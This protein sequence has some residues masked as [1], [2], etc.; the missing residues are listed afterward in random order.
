MVEFNLTLFIELGLFLFFLWL[1]KRMVFRPMLSVMDQREE[2]IARDL[3]EAR[4][5]ETEAQEIEEQYAR[6][7]AQ[8]RQ[9]AALERERRLQEARTERTRE[10]AQRRRKMLEEVE[11][12][13]EEVHRLIEQERTRYPDLV[14]EL[15]Q[16]LAGHSGLE[17]DN[18]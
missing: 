8:I 9:E 1:M 6:T 15:V 11:A 7:I 13:R 2:Q 18:A 4:K 5:A 12:T 17:G 3:A 16:A 10:L 14:Q